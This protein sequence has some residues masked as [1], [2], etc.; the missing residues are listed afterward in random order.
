VLPVASSHT[1]LPV[2]K[3]GHFVNLIA[4]APL[5]LIVE[6]IE[7]R[8]PRSSVGANSRAPGYSP[9]TGCPISIRTRVRSARI[10]MVQKLS[11]VLEKS[12]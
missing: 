3:T 6:D 4:D 9:F 2:D 8:A 5:A 11:Y 12:S 7:K 1:T 10:S